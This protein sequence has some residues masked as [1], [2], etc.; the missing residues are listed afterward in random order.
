LREAL[1]KEGTRVEFGMKMM[2]FAQDANGVRATLQHKDGRLEEVSAAYLI[3]AEGA[4]S[5]VRT[6]LHLEFQGKTLDEHY[7][8]GDLHADGDLPDYDL[9]LFS[10]EHGFMGL[11]PLGGS[12]FRLIA[13]NPPGSSPEEAAP[14]L[15]QLQAI[16]DQR[17][18]IP[19][20]L[21]HLD[22]SSWFHINSRMVDKLKVGRVFLGGD[23]AHIHSPAGGQGMN[24]GIQD[25]MNLAWKLALVLKGQASETLLDTYQEDRL[26]V[27]RSILI[28]TEGM[29]ELM[30]TEN[31]LIRS[32]FNHLAP[33]IGSL[34][35]VEEN[36]V[37]RISQLALHYRNSSLSANHP[38]GGSLRAGDRVPELHVRGAFSYR[39]DA[40]PEQEESRLFRFLSPS[41]FTLLLVHGEDAASLQA[42]ITKALEPWRELVTVVLVEPPNGEPAKK[43]RT[44]FGTGSSLVLVRP[45]A[46]V[47]FRGNEH[48]VPKLA[49][50]FRHWLSPSVRRRA[51]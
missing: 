41:R 18:H 33:W 47:G 21:R 17:S 9:H 31:P 11:F 40:H 2:A 42:Q 5:T 51:A 49:E 30:Q 25:M 26:P 14:S 38:A 15:E 37:A 36:A 12:H 34:D 45:D 35:F 50:Y 23:A 3:S 6:I 1:A 43:F 27:M 46:Y 10:S 32:V 8:L 13:N 29:T 20:R 48:A 28:R 16:Y 7:V 19:A 24:T 22:W 39:G 4:H 44:Y